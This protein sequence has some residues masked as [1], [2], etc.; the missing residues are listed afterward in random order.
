MSLECGGQKL[1]FHALD[2]IDIFINKIRLEVDKNQFYYHYADRYSTNNY[3]K[4]WGW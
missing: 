1:G 3:S 2:L 4:V